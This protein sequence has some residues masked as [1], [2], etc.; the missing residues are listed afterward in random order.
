MCKT[1][2]SVRSR[3]RLRASAQSLLDQRDAKSITVT[4]IVGLAGVT[5]PT[6]YAAYG[7]LP[8]AIA[9]AAL[10]RLTATFDE[11][12]LDTEGPA[13]RH[14]GEMIAAF[15]QIATRVQDDAE[16]YLR[17]T[18]GPGGMQI[19][20]SVNVFI[21]E[22]LRSHS[23]LSRAL[24]NSPVPV[25][26]STSALAA[27][28][29]WIALEWLSDPAGQSPSEFATAVRDLIVHAVNGGLARHDRELKVEEM[30]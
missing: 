17:A 10:H 12:S 7:D 28:V 14:A 23:P 22:R 18:H 1:N 26:L 29:T 24:Q 4:D 6:F 25:E 11:F 9:D 20:T 8:T 13:S 30:R 15:T 3:D 5:R 27:G 2:V 21:A 19:L 16:F